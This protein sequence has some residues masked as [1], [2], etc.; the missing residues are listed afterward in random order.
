[1]I[2]KNKNTYAI[3]FAVTLSVAS[4]GFISSYKM[5]PANALVQQNVIK[6]MTVIDI[7]IV[8]EFVQGNVDIV[9]WALN[10]SGVSKINIYLDDKFVGETGLS[11]SRPD[12]IKVF[13]EYNQ[14]DKV[15]FKYTLPAASL[16]EGQH[17]VTVEVVGKDKSISIK[18]RYINLK[19]SKWNPMTVIDFPY[20]NLSTAS[21]TIK[22]SGWSANS[23]GIKDIKILIDGKLVGNTKADKDRLDVQKAYYQY[24]IPLKTG[25]VYDIDTSTLK[26]G[27]NVLTVEAEGN[28][29]IISRQTKTFN[30]NRWSPFLFM[31]T[32]SNNSTINANSLNISGWTANYSGVKNIN[33]Y[34]DDNKIDTIEPN[35]DRPDAKAAFSQFNLP[36][37]TGYSYNLNLN[38]F[39]EGN[40][41]ITV[42]AIAN[43]GEKTS[44]SKNITVS[45]W[46]PIMYME[47]P[48]S[49]YSQEQNDVEVS[50]WAVN[51]SGIKSIK[52]LVDDVEVGEVQRTIDR[53]D[54]QAAFPT[55]FF[56]KKTG[57]KYNI[58]SSKL[59]VGNRKITVIA[60]GNDGSVHKKD[61]VIIIREKTFKYNIESLDN[62][63]TFKNSDISIVGWALGKTKVKSMNVYLDN[64]LIGNSIVNLQRLDV[65][66]V[67][68]QHNDENSGF[69]YIIPA[70]NI[71]PGIYE[72]KL[73]FIS[74]DGT[75]N[76]Y[77]CN[78][79]MVKPIPVMNLE[80][81]VEGD[82]TAEPIINVC[83]WALNASRIKEVQVYVD[84]I[85]KGNATLDVERLDVGR[86]FPE[87]PNKNNSGYKYSLN[88]QGLSLGSHKIKV[89]AI[90]TDGTEEIR[91]K[92]IDVNGRITYKIINQPLDYY[93]DRENTEGAPVVY[94][95]SSD[96]RA[97]RR[98]EIYYYMNPN[99]FLNS[100]ASRLMFL[101]LTYFDGITENNLNAALNN[102]GV[103]AGKGS[104]FLK[105][106][107][108]AN[109]NPIYLLSHA[110]LETGN[111]TSR[112][113]T[114]VL[115]DN[116]GGIPV[117]PRVVYNVYGIGARDGDAL[118]LGSEYAYKQGWFTVN[119][120][121][122]G[123]ARW[124]ASGYI[125]NSYYQ[126]DTLYKM[127]FNLND[128]DYWHQYSTDIAWASKQ[129]IRMKNLIDSMNRPVLYFEIPIFK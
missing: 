90:G 93:V 108:A 57:Y 34:V 111:G 117:V 54:V 27:N 121:I 76:Y 1:M 105:A 55:Y 37:R 106:G 47:T 116:L 14:E 21:N 26:S 51:Y 8:N 122:T 42:E 3:T 25:Y 124:I 56:E 96:I 89:K 10:Q 102:K 9:G 129:T 65:Q 46:N 99:N 45:K 6:P 120:A 50:G 43:N 60:N 85:Y 98:E 110:L 101:K 32:P 63:N 22:I 19:L 107:Q 113:A 87:Y 30:V 114:G 92:S 49:E 74:E 86:V 16:S 59:P 67:F 33:I 123:G 35:V 69:K 112:L 31:D 91:E 70:D 7:P 104:V 5:I 41:K 94:N 82:V 4:Y 127:R 75:K 48:T 40:K 62:N 125:A 109:V 88:T 77:T 71:K 64:K 2:K 11:I 24:N 12:V 15:G 39:S 103:L 78:F 66:K 100:D 18:D 95:S 36:L 29:G 61:R 126:Q 128:K 115:V 84:N 119:D 28:N 97:A 38:N 44:I 73:E 58:P 72:L 23:S 68:P 83:G 20:N 118:R 17:K 52:I 13:P 81:P 79:V 53:P 80:S